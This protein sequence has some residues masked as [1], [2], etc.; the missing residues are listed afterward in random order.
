[1][2]I[3]GVVRVAQRQ[4]FYY[5]YD[6]FFFSSCFFLSFW[7]FVFSVFV[8]KSGFHLIVAKFLQESKMHFD[9][10]TGSVRDLRLSDNSLDIY[11]AVH[12]CF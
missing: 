2:S 6:F 10:A 1:M 5:E 11:M 12:F 7:Y 8:G 4:L 9:L 3:L